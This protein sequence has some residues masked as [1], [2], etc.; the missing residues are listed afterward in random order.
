[1]SI[2]IAHNG[3]VFYRAGDGAYIF[4]SVLGIILS[5]V[6]FIIYALN[7]NRVRGLNKIVWELLVSYDRNSY[8]MLRNSVLSFLFF[9]VVVTDCFQAVPM[10]SL[11][12]ACAVFE[13]RLVSYYL[14][15]YS[16]RGSYAA[17]SVSE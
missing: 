5:L 7:L 6:F 9:K 1:M 13:S 2:A 15:F 14:A 10:L 16:R 12:I 11:A 17:A 4:F 3:T 8:E